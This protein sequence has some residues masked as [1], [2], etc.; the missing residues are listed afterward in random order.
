M[1]KNDFKKLRVGL[2]RSCGLSSGFTEAPARKAGVGTGWFLVT[3]SDSIPALHFYTLT[4]IPISFTSRTPLQISFH[5]Y[6]LNGE[7][8]FESQSEY[9][10][11]N[12]VCLSV[13]PL[14]NLFAR[15]K[16]YGLPSGFTGAPARKAGVGTG[17][18]L[19]SKSLTLPLASLKARE[20]IG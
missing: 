1:E 13:S 17:W 3:I 10:N 8:T 7:G 14:V 12:N 9:I 6:A 19:L 15:F 2:I 5:K 11:I 16:V 20:V 4:F 18:L